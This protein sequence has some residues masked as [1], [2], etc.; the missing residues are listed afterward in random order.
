ML[1]KVTSIEGKLSNLTDVLS[2]LK[3]IQEDTNRNVVSEEMKETEDPQPKPSMKKS[4]KEAVQGHGD[5]V[6][7]VSEQKQKKKKSITWFGT[8]I[9]KV[10]DVKKLKNDTKTDLKIV[11]AYC[12]QKEGM[13]PKSNFCAVVLHELRKE[14]ADVVVLQTGSIE[15]TNIDVRK[16]MMD[17]IKDI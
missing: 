11:R 15:I 1:K 9:S 6:K 4:Y 7:V 5:G 16:A 17:P 8:S 14:P 10:L 2:E 13:Y 3:D 12:I